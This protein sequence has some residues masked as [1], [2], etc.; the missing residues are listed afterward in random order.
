MDV[1]FKERILDFALQIIHLAN[2]LPKNPAGSVLER[3]LVRAGTSVGANVHE[4][5]VAFSVNEWLYCMNVA[6]KEAKETC[7]WV[8]LIRRAEM[9]PS[10]S[11][12]RIEAELDEIIGIPTKSIKTAQTKGRLGKF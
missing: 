8:T 10:T 2:A 4:A 5:E 7:Y 11:F 1:A 6:K 9:A 12:K 3:Q